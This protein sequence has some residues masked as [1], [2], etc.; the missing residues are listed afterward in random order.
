MPP[1][2]SLP[3][4]RQSKTV[5]PIAA[6]RLYPKKIPVGNKP[7]VELSNRNTATVL[8]QAAYDSFENLVMASDG[9]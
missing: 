4:I 1:S 9:R 2:P 3:A 6:V 8:I 5:W 7:C